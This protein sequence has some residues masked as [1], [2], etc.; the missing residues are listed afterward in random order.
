MKAVILAAGYAT[1]LGKLTENQ[2]KPL[3]KVGGKPLL[4]HILSRIRSVKE[5]TEVYVVTNARF[6]DHFRIWSNDFAYPKKITLINDGTLSLDDRLGAIGDINFLLKEEDVDSDLLVIGGDNLF[7]ED[8]STMIKEF[9]RR[10]GSMVSY[11]DVKDKQLAKL[12][13]IVT[14]DHSGK[15][16]RFSEKPAN[17]ESTLASTLIYV[18]KK[19]HLALVSE[20]ISKGYADHA[21][22]FIKFLIQ[23]KPVYG[24]ALLGRWFDI[25]SLEQLKEAER[26]FKPKK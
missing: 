19:D 22:D 14:L 7:E 4:E 25:G 26:Y 21:G 20:A 15:I 13:G 16:V 2:P 10:D 9:C 8:L 17:P 12:Y 1:R 5:I 18:L 6:Y 24:Y 23:K 3:L 11:T